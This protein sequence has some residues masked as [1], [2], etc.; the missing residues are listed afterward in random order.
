MSNSSTYAT[1]GVAVSAMRHP[2]HTGKRQADKLQAYNLKIDTA[3]YAFALAI[4]LPTFLPAAYYS[5]PPRHPTT[6]KNLYVA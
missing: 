3:R 1:L 4:I 2:Q 6:Y 5:T